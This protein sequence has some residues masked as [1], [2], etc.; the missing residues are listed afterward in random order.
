MNKFSLDEL[1]T[2]DLLAALG[3]WVILE[4]ISFIVFPALRLIEPAGRL[5]GWFLISL[6]IGVGGAFLVAASSRFVAE[7]NERDR[8]DGKVWQ[9]WLGQFGGSLGLIGIMFPLIMVSIEFLARA[10]A[11]LENL[12]KS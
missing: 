1:V 7:S 6:P 12:E 5:Q 2:K 9:V 4:I 10:I 8:G 11:E 3:L